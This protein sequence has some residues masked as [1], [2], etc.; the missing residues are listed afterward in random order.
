MEVVYIEQQAQ[1]LTTANI[2]DNELKNQLKQKFNLL[3]R[4]SSR[5]TLISL[6]GAM[7]IKINNPN[8]GVYLTSSFSSPSNMRQLEIDVLEHKT[9][10]PFNFINS[11]NN[12]VS[13]YVA[14]SLKINGPNLFIA[15]ESANWSHILLPAMLDLN[16]GVVEQA[17]VGW[18]Y[19]SRREQ[20]LNDQEGSHWVLL[21]KHYKHASAKMMLEQGSYQQNKARKADSYYYHAVNEMFEFLN[22]YSITTW[23]SL[24]LLDQ[25][26]TIQR[27]TNS[28]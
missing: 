24:F 7:S 13:F 21:S 18:C 2:H 3:S 5:L 17:L 6:L 28:S 1:Y 12:A 20:D 15:T 26:L 9:P 4:R 19:E 16:L 14:Q 23:E 25:R 27:L 8:C 11:I 22:Q 10:R